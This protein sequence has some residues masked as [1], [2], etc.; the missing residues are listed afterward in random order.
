[1]VL[2]WENQDNFDRHS[3]RASI[4]MEYEPLDGLRLNK[5]VYHACFNVPDESPDSTGISELLLVFI[6]GIFLFFVTLRYV[7][8]N[9]ISK[10]INNDEL[11]ESD[12]F[13]GKTGG[14]SS[15]CI[16]REVARTLYRW[17]VRKK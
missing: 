4:K 3:R 5:R 16:I 12:K 9:A 13:D 1:M 2:G 6:N 8:H 15:L 10:K 7:T 11:N 17:N 14:S